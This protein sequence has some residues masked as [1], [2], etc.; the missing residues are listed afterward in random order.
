NLKH[1]REVYQ[2]TVEQLFTFHIVNLKHKFVDVLNK[3]GGLFTFHIVNLKHLR[4]VYQ[5]TVEQLFT[6]HIVN[7]KPPK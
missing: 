7:L 1:L 2:Q 3:F 6:F 4:E 5:Q